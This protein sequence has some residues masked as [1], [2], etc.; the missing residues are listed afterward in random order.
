MRA[1]GSKLSVV[2]VK[3]VDDNG[4]NDEQGRKEEAV[5]G[6]GCERGESFGRKRQEAEGK[7]TEEAQEVVPPTCCSKP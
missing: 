5:D 2:F 7:I 6:A 1:C 3:T 4:E